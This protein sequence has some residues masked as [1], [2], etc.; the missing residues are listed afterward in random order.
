MH[1]SHNATK[2]P[3]PG[4]TAYA[5]RLTCFATLRRL[6]DNTLLRRTRYVL[7]GA[8]QL[9]NSTLADTRVTRRG[10]QLVLGDSLF[11]AVGANVYWLGARSRRLPLLRSRVATYP[12]RHTGLDENV[13]PSPSYPSKDRVLEA[14]AIAAA[15]GAS[16]CT[17]T[18][19][20]ITSS[21]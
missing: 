15:M 2:R 6:T 3:Q 17:F 14:F 12:L 20:P 13:E 9:P 19:L 11:H 16:T 21:R 18:V 8:T 5:L 1:L 10:R 4:M 7:S